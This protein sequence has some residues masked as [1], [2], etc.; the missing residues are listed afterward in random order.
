MQEHAMPATS[1]RSQ[2]RWSGLG[3]GKSWDDGV[4]VWSGPSA[5]SQLVSLGDDSTVG[6]LF[7]AGSKMAYETISFAQVKVYKVLLTI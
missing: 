3:Q 5:Y 2:P 6:V 7:E 4:P 1:I